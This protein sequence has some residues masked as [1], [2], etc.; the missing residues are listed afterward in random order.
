[1]G[2]LECWY[3]TN[4]LSSG[5][6]G[7]DWQQQPVVLQTSSAEVS[8]GVKCERGV[9]LLLIW[10]LFELDP[11]WGRSRASFVTCRSA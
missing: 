2:T 10:P 8:V 3:L 5:R 4:V 1:M 7:T 9:K 11:M 6:L